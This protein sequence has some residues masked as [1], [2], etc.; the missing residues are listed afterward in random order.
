MR[1]TIAVPTADESV[2]EAAWSRS[3]GGFCCGVSLVLPILL[4]RKFFGYYMIRACLIAGRAVGRLNKRRQR[5]RNEE[6][7]ASTW[8]LIAKR[9]LLSLVGSFQ[10]AILGGCHSF[11]RQRCC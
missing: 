3:C 9:G 4:G 7:R 2:N 10:M 6:S 5:C 1:A 8:W 11:S